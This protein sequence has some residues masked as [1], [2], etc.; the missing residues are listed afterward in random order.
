MERKASDADKQEILLRIGYALQLGTSP[1]LKLLD[2]QNSNVHFSIIYI[3][4]FGFLCD[5]F[6]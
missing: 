6:G 5:I 1:I 2:Y 4:M 3:N